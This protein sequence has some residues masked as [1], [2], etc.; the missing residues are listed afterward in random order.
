MRKLI[1]EIMC[2]GTFLFMGLAASDSYAA[3]LAEVQVHPTEYSLIDKIACGPWQ[4][5]AGKHACPPGFHPKQG[6]C[7]PCHGFAV[8]SC[9]GR[10]L[11]NQCWCNKNGTNYICCDKPAC[12]STILSV[13]GVRCP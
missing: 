1:V 7:V 4:A 12:R 2:I 13:L 11:A 5:F 6:M 9:G 8:N 10:C 3:P